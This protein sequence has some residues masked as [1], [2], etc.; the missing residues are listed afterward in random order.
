MLIV[1]NSESEKN[2]DWSKVDGGEE[3]Q[4]EWE[5]L[6]NFNQ[7]YSSKIFRTFLTVLGLMEIV[8]L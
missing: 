6:Q 8:T 7:K 4:A 1:D 3:F 5:L 2:F